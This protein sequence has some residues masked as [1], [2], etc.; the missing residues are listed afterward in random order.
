VNSAKLPK[1]A[2]QLPMVLED[3]HN[4]TT[5]KLC[6]LQMFAVTTTVTVRV[7]YLQKTPKFKLFCDAYDL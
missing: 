2:G 6:T 3:S 7:E 1:R 4:P 5:V